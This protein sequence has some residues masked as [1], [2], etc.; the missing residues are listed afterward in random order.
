MGNIDEA[1]RLYSL[2][3]DRG[4]ALSTC[5]LGYR[6]LHGNGMRRNWP[7]AANLL[8]KA[9]RMGV[10]NFDLA[11]LYENGIGGVE[12]NPEY[13]VRLLTD[14]YHAGEQFST[15]YLA[16]CY[17]RGVGVK[18]DFAKAA[19]LLRE[20]K[21]MGVYGRR[22]QGYLGLMMIQGLGEEQNVK[23][24]LKLVKKGLRKNF[25]CGWACYA[26]CYRYGLGVKKIIIIRWLLLAG[27]EL[28]VFA[29]DMW[30]LRKCLRPERAY[31]LVRN[32]LHF[33]ILKLPTE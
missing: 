5:S 30:R 31:H 15:S 11:A 25:G 13:A 12:R 24:G 17:Y 16:W 7:R 10:L 6:C 21:E 20:L 3:A 2:A 18:Q 14:A 23:S 9:R 22:Y 27:A 29:T 4:S 19:S 32:K 26:D 1:V 28:V 8:E 33:T